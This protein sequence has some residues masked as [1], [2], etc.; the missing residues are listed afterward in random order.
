MLMYKHHNV[1]H[2]LN[3][4]D[5]DILS[6]ELRTEEIAVYGSVDDAWMNV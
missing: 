1:T 6:V 2:F 5:G 3:E 4:A